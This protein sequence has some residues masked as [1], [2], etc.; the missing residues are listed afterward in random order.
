MKSV[1]TYIRQA[2][3]NGTSRA[4]LLLALILFVWSRF[5]LGGLNTKL[6]D[7][8]LVLSLPLI[9]AAIG[10]TLVIITGQFDLSAA[11][12]MTIVNVLVATTFSEVNALLVVALMILLGAF[13]GTVNG[14]FVVYGK[15]PAIAV[16]LATLIILQGLALVLLPQPGGSVPPALVSLVKDPLVVPRA[17]IIILL[18]VICWMIFKR[19]RLGLYMFALGE[20]EEAFRLSGVAV[21]PVRITIFALAG[22]LYAVAGMLLS[23]VTESAD[24]TIGDTYLLATFAAIAIGGTAFI[25]GY[26]SALGT[27]LGALI[28]VA[29]PKVLFVL[30]VSNWMVSVAQ[31]IIIIAA[32][33]V[34]AIAARKQLTDQFLALRPNATIE[35]NETASNEGRA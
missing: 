12:V 25:G 20:D 33:L 14:L 5:Q 32:V 8:Y 21:K 2:L 6:I 18:I 26:G 9:V 3:T 10:V 34:G 11:G 35:T 15:L 1:G 24:A 22:A 28:L 29:I 16:T 4:F 23:V 7:S 27:L 31:G 19:T 30:Q 17:L 13:I